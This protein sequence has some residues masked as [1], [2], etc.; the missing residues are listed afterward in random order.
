M[1]QT[2]NSEKNF[3]LN[4]SQS[5]KGTFAA[6]W[7]VRADNITELAQRNEEV[8]QLA[9]EQLKILNGKIE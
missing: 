7:T 6:E 3:R 8:K 1:E 2:N 9:L 5:A 4:F